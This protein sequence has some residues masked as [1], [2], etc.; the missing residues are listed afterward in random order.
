MNWYKLSKKM[1]DNMS[2]QDFI[3]YHRT[4]FIPSSAYEKYKTKQGFDWIKK[5]K[6]PILHSTNIFNG[7]LVEFRQ[8][9]EKNR[10]CAHDENKELIRGPDGIAVMMSDEEITDK[11]LPLYDTSIAAFVGEDAVGL[12]SDEWGADGVWVVE[13]YQRMGIGTYLIYEFRKQFK[14]ERKLG[15]MTNAGYNLARSYYRRLKNE[16]L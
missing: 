6:Y 15:Q 1:Y 13:E 12:A 5:D 4:G 11:G 8:S 3:D 14:D 9:G 7:T 16:N 10:Y 2:E